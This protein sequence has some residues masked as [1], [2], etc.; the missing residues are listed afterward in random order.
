[1][2]LIMSSWMPLGFT[3]RWYDTCPVPSASRLRPDPVVAPDVVAARDRRLDAGRIG[4]VAA[5]G[6]VQRIGV[7]ATHTEVCCA[8]WSPCSGL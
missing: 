5:E 1:M 2:V 6:E 8:I 3:M 7:V 4:I